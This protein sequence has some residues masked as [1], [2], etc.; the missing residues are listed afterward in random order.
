MEIKIPDLKGKRGS[1]VLGQLLGQLLT[2][3]LMSDSWV[4]WVFMDLP[5]PQSGGQV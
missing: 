4:W 5:E 2:W 1:G 3:A